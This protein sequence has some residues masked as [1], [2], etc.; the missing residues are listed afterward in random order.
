M[1]QSAYL[2]SG[3]DKHSGRRVLW[4]RGPGAPAAILRK[5]GGGTPADD[6]AGF[7]RPTR[8]L[9]LVGA[10]AT[11]LLTPTHILILLAILLLLFGAKRLPETGRALGHSMR[12]FKDAITGHA[13]T[14]VDPGPASLEAPARKSTN[15][16]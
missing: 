12:E 13:D 1:A 15:Q 3:C 7:H 10:M 4:P 11:S 16:G 5:L 14:S 9:P 8:H 6:L 2:L